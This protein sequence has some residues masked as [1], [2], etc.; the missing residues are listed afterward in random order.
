MKKMTDLNLG[1][2]LYTTIIFYI[3]D[4]WLNLRNGYDLY[5]WQHDSEN[6]LQVSDVQ[7]TA[8]R[9]LTCTLRILLCWQMIFFRF[10]LLTSP[11]LVQMEVKNLNLLVEELKGKIGEL[12]E[13]NEN[14]KERLRKRKENKRQQMKRWRE[15]NRET[16]LEQ[17]R[18]AN[19]KRKQRERDNQGYVEE[20]RVKTEP[21]D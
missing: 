14:L 12:E 9:L 16:Y 13:E 3:P 6:P 5:F 7:N 10:D 8:S 20:V 15:K 4:S 17:K 21:S 18:R 1:Q 19:Q 11:L 2:L